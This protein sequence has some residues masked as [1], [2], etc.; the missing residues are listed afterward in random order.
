MN[1]TGNIGEIKK[2]YKPLR[3]RT[4]KLLQES[5]IQK[6]SPQY[7]I[8][9]KKFSREAY[10]AGIDEVTQLPVRSGFESRLLE[11]F[12]RSER[13]RKPLTMAIID[14]NYLKKINSEQGLPG[15]DRALREV[16]KQIIISIRKTDY[17]ARYGG[18]EFA[19]LFPEAKVEDIKNWWDRFKTGMES[20]P[21]TITASAIA[22]T[23]QNIEESRMTLSDM[24]K[25]A[26][27]QNGHNT[28]AFVLAQ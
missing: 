10:M 4:E 13:N 22:V 28:N 2:R 15:G 23:K 5:G 21:Y 16:A 14:L 20:T 24:V 11:E 6:N 7:N 27:D 3:E 18:D 9:R 26:K 19:I 25:K 8:A 17:A 12:S 1:E